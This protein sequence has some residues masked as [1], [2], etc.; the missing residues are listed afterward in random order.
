MPPASRT[1]TWSQAR[2]IALRSQGIGARRNQRMPSR[3]ASRSAL[4]RTV[5]RT[6]L[7]QIDSVSVF[8]RAHHMPVFT[9]R[10]CWDVAELDRASAPGPRR[11]L[12]EC[13]AHE[14]T[15]ATTE[16]HGLLGFRRAAVAER[17]WGAV[18]RAAGADEGVLR[19]VLEAIGERGPISAAA[20]ARALGDAERPEEGWGWRRTDTQWVVEYLF[21][22]GRLECVGRNAQFERLYTLPADDDAPEV[23]R[24]EAVGR[25]TSLAAR[26]LGIATPASIADYFRL[27]QR[28]V[29]PALAA[30]RERG[31]LEP[32]AVR[33]GGLDA[34]MLLHHEAPA[35]APLRGAALVSPFDPI[36]F[37]RPRLAALYDVEYRIG[38]YTP[39]AA[40]PHGY[41]ALPFLMGDRFVARVDLAADRRAGLLIVHEAHLEPLPRLRH[42]P[43]GARALEPGLVAAALAEEL[44]RAA[45]WQGAAA[46]AVGGR[47]DLASPLAAA[48][49]DRGMLAGQRAS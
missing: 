23:P 25:L 1:L 21:R 32:V 27:P 37:H 31:E 2:R 41:Y 20:L 4:H 13:L 24:H 39:R 34:P 17:D 28:D 46:I 48:V 16:V 45:A 3:A 47:G 26:A 19:G 43:G 9:R 10:G 38:I 30:L 22:A 7:L 36:A 44:E 12:R 49:A 33:L 6:H 29:A 8:A 15:L 5:E 18:R 40:R 42:A 14:A 11:V 35:P